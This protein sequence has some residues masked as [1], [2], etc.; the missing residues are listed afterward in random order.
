MGKAAFYITEVLC[1]VMV[2]WGEGSLR[3]FLT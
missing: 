2:G 3:S 1:L